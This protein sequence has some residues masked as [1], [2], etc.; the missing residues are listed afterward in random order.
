MHFYHDRQALLTLAEHRPI[1]EGEAAMLAAT[2]RFVA[3]N[4]ECC[5]PDFAPGHVT[6]SAWI[7]DPLRRAALMTHHRKLDRWF[8]LGG[9]LEPGESV[10]AGAR[11]EAIE[12][13]GLAEL[14]LITPAIFDIDVHLIPARGEIAA[15]YHYDVRFWFEADPAERVQASKESRA[16]A[17]VS[18]HE[19]ARYNDSESILRMVRKTQGS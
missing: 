3:E 2:L 6:G 8:Q 7:V 16:L 1:D 4:A 9:H 5:S 10:E 17:W 19:A 15:H 12:E 11:R 18:L 14:R 13:S